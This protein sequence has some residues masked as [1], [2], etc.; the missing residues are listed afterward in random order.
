MAAFI[1][2]ATRMGASVALA[3]AL[4][5]ASCDETKDAS[6]NSNDSPPR[7]AESMGDAWK[8]ESQPRQARWTPGGGEAAAPPQPGAG[9]EP[10]N[11]S[12]QGWA[13]VLG[14]STAEN[15]REQAQK[16]IDGWRDACPYTD[17]WIESDERGS[18]LRYGS[19]PAMDSKAAQADLTNLK[20]FVYNNARPFAGAYLSRIA[21]SPSGRL[22]EYNLI[23]ARRLFPREDTVYSLQI[24]VYEA[25]K[26][27][28][29]GN[30]TT[31]EEARRLAEQAVT[32]LR[33]Q[34]EMAFYYHSP[35]RSMV[36]IGAFPSS[37]VDAA[38]GFYTPD[39]MALQRRYPHNALNGRTLNQKIL[40][41]SGKFREETQPSFLVRVPDE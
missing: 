14:T 5:L 38:T 17:M 33:A 40:T 11:T 22:R 21:S 30:N 26:D 23:Q 37:A 10:A 34:G 13:L 7:P 31:T 27:T 28:T 3:T 24:G 4:A 36:C 35:N 12:R 2:T 1:G 20:H 19:Y 18:I 8:A 16:F 6:I 32:Q 41:N 9:T 29:T 15:H 25:E 39:V